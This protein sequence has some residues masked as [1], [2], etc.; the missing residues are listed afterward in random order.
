MQGFIKIEHSD[1]SI[2]YVNEN[3]D[4]MIA[5]RTEKNSQ[6][7][8][9]DLIGL[10]DDQLQERIL[11]DHKN[12]IRIERDRRLTECDWTQGL[13]SPLSEDQK[14][15]WKIYRQNLRDLPS[16]I[17]DTSIVIWPQKP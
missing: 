8:P 17:T 15:L 16:N 6:S 11:N 10:S 7:V 9:D 4:D 1:G 13:D 2:E 5:N 14:N 12:C 3:Y